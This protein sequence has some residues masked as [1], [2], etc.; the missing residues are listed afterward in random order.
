MIVRDPFVQYSDAFDSGFCC[1]HE[2]HAGEAVAQLKPKKWKD[3]R[4]ERDWLRKLCGRDGVVLLVSRVYVC[5]QGRE[6]AAR[7]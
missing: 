5:P 4:S 2:C 7:D 3:G 1:P 6:I